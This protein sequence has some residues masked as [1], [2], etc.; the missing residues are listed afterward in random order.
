MRVGGDNAGFGDEEAGS[1]TIQRFQTNNGGFGPANQLFEGKFLEQRNGESCGC[2]ANATGKRA[3][4]SF[5]IDVEMIGF[6]EP[7]LAVMPAV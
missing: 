1:G 3:G 6:E 4:D 5:E 2:G 7:I